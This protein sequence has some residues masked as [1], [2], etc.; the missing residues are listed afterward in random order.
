LGKKLA[1]GR[2]RRRSLPQAGLPTDTCL[3]CGHSPG[4][5]DCALFVPMYGPTV[6]AK[7]L[8]GRGTAY[9]YGDVVVPRCPDCHRR[10]AGLAKRIEGWH[11]RAL[12]KGDQE[13]FPEAVGA[14]AK[15]REE[16]RE[17]EEISAIAGRAVERAQAGRRWAIGKQWLIGRILRR[18]NPA[19]DAADTA[20][21][22]AQHQEGVAVG[23]HRDIVAEQKRVEAELVV[24][25]EAAIAA[26]KSAYAQPALPVNVRPEKDWPQ[27]PLV[28]ERLSQSWGLGTSADSTAEEKEARETVSRPPQLREPDLEFV[29]SDCRVEQA[30]EVV[31]CS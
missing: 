11:E 16:A 19:R 29:A 9:E 10:H 27:A 20:L 31:C 23:L 17:L 8:L 15:A 26:H 5:A 22:A 2:V 25:R 1:K 13:H 21:A 28:A 30:E 6:Q 12:H 3:F 4:S 14:V 7:F 24:L 18:P